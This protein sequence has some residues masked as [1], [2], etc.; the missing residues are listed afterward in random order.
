[1]RTLVLWLAIGVADALLLWQFRS[2]E[3]VAAYVA[4]GMLVLLN[5]AVGL[6]IGQS[7]AAAYLEE[8]VRRN[9][10]LAEQNADLTDCNRRLLDR[11]A[12]RTASG[13]AV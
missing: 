7:A 11:A 8:V 12:R 10:L 2:A 9:R 3:P 6:R 5:V 13:E 4:G 1:M